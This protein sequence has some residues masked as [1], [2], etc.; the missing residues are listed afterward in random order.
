ME[1]EELIGG[2]PGG[3]IPIALETETVRVSGQ[4]EKTYYLMFYTM[5]GLN[6]WNSSF[7]FDS[8]ADA[9]E[10]ISSLTGVDKIRLVRVSLP[11]LTPTGAVFV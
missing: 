8:E 3:G 6:D 11:V 10:S 4:L 2:I 1:D 7:P 9:V 5:H